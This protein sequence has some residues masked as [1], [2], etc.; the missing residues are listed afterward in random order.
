M[1]CYLKDR[2][3]SELNFVIMSLLMGRRTTMK[4][5]KG[6]NAK[7][8]RRQYNTIQRLCS[9]GF[10]GALEICILL[11]LLLIQYNTIQYKTC[12][13]PYVT[14]KLFVGDGKEPT[15]LLNN[16]ELN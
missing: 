15:N 9:L 3:W 14:R 6:V 7:E 1:G 11:L 12:N 4:C 2:N 5:V 10:Y 16:T 8:I 13:A